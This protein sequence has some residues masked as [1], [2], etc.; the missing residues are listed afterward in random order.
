MDKPIVKDIIL[1]SGSR[2]LR[3]DSIEDLFYYDD[4][5][6]N[7]RGLGMAY[8]NS[9]EIA[10]YKRKRVFLSP[11]KQKFIED[12]QKEV[13]MDQDFLKLVY[14]GKSQKRKQN[15]NKFVGNLSIPQYAKCSDKLFLRGQPGAKKQVLNLAFQVGTFVGGNYE[16]TFKKILKT[17]LM[18]QAMNISVNIDMFDSDVRAIHGGNAYIIVNVSRSCEKI[19]FKRIMTASYRNFFNYS[20]FNGYSASGNTG[21][22]DRFLPS[23]LIIQDLSP[24]YDVIGGNLLSEEQDEMVSKI[25][26][27]GLNIS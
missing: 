17:I 2:L 21:Y 13:S 9:E 1:P 7:P 8:A 10:N 22:I 15:L 27:I 18:C 16:E 5:L 20:L 4:P 11:Q 6:N 3:F 24:F 26:K 19:N 25:L 14:Q 23:S 12:V